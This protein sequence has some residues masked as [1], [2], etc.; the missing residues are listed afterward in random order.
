MNDVPEKTS[1][2][3][4]PLFIAFFS[5]SND[6][7]LALAELMAEGISEQDITLVKLGIDGQSNQPD[8]LENVIEPFGNQR[9]INPDQASGYSTRESRVGGGIDTSS[10]DDDVS[11]IEEMDESESEAEDLMY[12]PNGK[13]IGD[14]EAQE[15]RQGAD[16]GFFE[17]TRPSPRKS[18]HAEPILTQIHLPD[19]GLVLGEGSFGEE[20]IEVSIGVGAVSGLEL[21]INQYSAWIAKAPA[22][23]RS[24]GAILAVDVE[25]TGP[26]DDRITDI[27]TAHGA[28]AMGTVKPSKRVSRLQFGE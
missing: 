1:T 12:P 16:S 15:V 2:R 9:L 19:I 13:S 28:K 18:R 24:M 10:P 17:T 20:L 22:E 21:L 27:V 6:A 7:E 4:A 3:T 23:L 25:I 8:A 5:H 26:V 11:A 14:E